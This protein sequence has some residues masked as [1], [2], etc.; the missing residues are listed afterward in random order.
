MAEPILR[1]HN[2]EL[3]KRIVETKTYCDNCGKELKPFEGMIYDLCNDC[4]KK[5]VKNNWDKIREVAGK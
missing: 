1:K 5:G 2:P 3:F 4:E